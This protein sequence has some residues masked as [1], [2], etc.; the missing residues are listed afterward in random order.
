MKKDLTGQ[1]FGDLYVVGVSE[2]SRN[3]HYRYHV[4]CSCGIEKTVFGTHLIQGNTKG[5][6][7]CKEKQKPRN[8]SGCGSVSGSYFSHVKRGASGSRGRKPIHFDLTIEHLA[9][10][11]DN[12]QMGKCALSGLPISV[13]D[14]TASLDRIDSSKGYV[15]GNVQWLHKDINMMKRHYNQDYFIHLCKKVGGACEIVDL[16]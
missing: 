10:L 14:H 16:T 3:G 11:L 8:W 5:C 12:V 2:I 1:T 7:K 4:K 15:E 6:G 13:K 9:D